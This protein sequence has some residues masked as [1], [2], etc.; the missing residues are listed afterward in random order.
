[1]PCE[2]GRAGQLERHLEAL[3]GCAR[4]VKDMKKT[5]LTIGLCLA[6]ALVVSATSPIPSHPPAPSITATKAIEAA[7]KFMDTASNGVRYCSSV[8]LVEGGMTPAP[9]GS[10]RHWLVTFQDAGG[11]RAEPRHVYVNMEGVASNEVPPASAEV[12]AQIRNRAD[13]LLSA[14]RSRQWTKCVSFVAVT[15]DTETLRRMGLSKDASS[16][17]IE[18][19]VASWFKGLYDVVQPGGVSAVR[20]RKDD[21]NLALIE[22]KHEDLDGF[23]MRRIDGEWYYTLDERVAPSAPANVASPHH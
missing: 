9:S 13:G 18:E 7:T 1:M 12:A 11:N 10:A 3:R 16:D 22:Y 19:K 21:E 15:K 6:T 5:I 2:T 8:T 17:L 14:I 20:I 23:Y 4:K